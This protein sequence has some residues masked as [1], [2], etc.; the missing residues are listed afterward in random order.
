M[1]L[2][3]TSST[4]TSIDA[5][6]RKLIIGIVV[7]TLLTLAGVI[8]DLAGGG[9]P[10]PPTLRAAATLLDGAWR[11]H[12]GDDP[13]WADANT[14]DS[15]W[16][17]FDMTASPGSHDGDVGLPD[18]VGGWMAHGHPGYHGYAWYRRAVTVPPITGVVGHSRADPRRERLRTLLERSTARRVGQA[19]P[20]PAR[21]RHAATAVRASRRCGRRPWRARCPHIHA[22][23]FGGFLRRRRHAQ[24]A[25]TGSAADK[26]RAP[27]RAMGAN[28]RRLHRRCDRADRHGGTHRLGARVAVLQQSQGF[29]DLCQHRACADGS[30]APQQCNRRMDRS[31]ESDYLSV[32]GVSDVGTCGGRLDVGLEPMVPAS[33]AK[34]RC[35][36]CSAGGRGDYNDEIQSASV[37]RGSRLASIAL[38]VVIGARIVRSGPMRILALVTL[39]SVMAG[40]FG[41]ELLDPIGVP[42]IWFPFGIGVSRTQYIYAMVIPLLAFFIVRTLPPRRASMKSWWK[43]RES[44]PRPRHYECRALRACQGP[45][46]VGRRGTMG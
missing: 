4:A 38:F 6:Q 3:P 20:S 46:D 22:S 7:A 42:G 30:Q 15:G 8:A 45:I 18:Y 31:A 2:E 37:T 33:V 27:P 32:A 24:R 28:H 14:D 9:R 40:L 36:G 16:E 21:R 43:G 12:T 35:V 5:I 44:N 17:T 19:R 10:D 39:A 1:T 26:R 34:H 29:L 13:H 23:Q 25:H 41:G 11:F